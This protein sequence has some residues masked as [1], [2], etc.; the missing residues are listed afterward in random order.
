M[1]FI[2]FETQACRILSK[3]SLP[4]YCQE[5]AWPGKIYE[6][7]HAGVLF[8]IREGTLGL[9]LWR[10][11]LNGER[12]VTCWCSGPCYTTSMQQFRVDPHLSLVNSN[13]VGSGKPLVGLDVAHTILQVPESLCQIHLQQVPEKVLEVRAEVRWE[14]DLHRHR[15]GEGDFRLPASSLLISYRLFSRTDHYVNGRR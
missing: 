15:A 2:S 3:I 6:W 13:P 4:Q 8:H 12:T 10:I 9:T 1:T 14:S 7:N 5:L 11:S